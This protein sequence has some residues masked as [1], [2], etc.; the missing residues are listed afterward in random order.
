MDQDNN[1]PSKFGTFAKFF[2]KDYIGSSVDYGKS[3][4]SKRNFASTA[5]PHH[6]FYSSTNYKNTDRYN[7]KD[8]SIIK[9]GL[10]SYGNTRGKDEF[11]TISQLKAD[12]NV[13]SNK[14][15]E[16]EMF[17]FYGK[18]AV[19]YARESSE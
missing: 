10:D 15:V 16:Q 12:Q 19:P 4:R 2:Q 1:S 7:N 14:Q 13:M 17:K 6:K 3:Y 8:L 11:P 18:Y 9:Y 5:K